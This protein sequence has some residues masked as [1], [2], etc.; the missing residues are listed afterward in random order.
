MGFTNKKNYCIIS[1]PPTTESR[2][3]LGHRPYPQSPRYRRR[4]ENNTLRGRRRSCPIDT[5]HIASN[6]CKPQ[7]Y[8]FEQINFN[9]LHDVLLVVVVRVVNITKSSWITPPPHVHGRMCCTPQQQPPSLRNIKPP[10][11]TLTAC[12]VHQRR[13]QDFHIGHR[14]YPQ[15]PRRPTS[16]VNGRHRPYLASWQSREADPRRERIPNWWNF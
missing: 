14:P 15:S 12:L 3:S 13:N 10:I 9:I 8:S 1:C 5:N 11:T 6:S 16:V 4:I 7:N 2:L